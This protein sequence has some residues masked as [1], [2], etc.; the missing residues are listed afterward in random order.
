VSGQ[1]QCSLVIPANV[2]PGTYTLTAFGVSASGNATSAPVIISVERPDAPVEITVA[3]ASLYLP[4]GARAPLR[5]MGTYADGTQLDISHSASTTFSSTSTSVATVDTQGYVTAVGP[6]HGQVPPHIV[7][8]NS[9]N[10]PVVVPPALS[11]TPQYP[12]LYASQRAQFSAF[13]SGMAPVAVN[14]SVSP[15]IGSINNSGVYTAPKS[16]TAQ[17]AVKVIATVRGNPSQ[18]ISTEVVLYPPVSISIMPNT[19]L[20]ALPGQT[21]YFLQ[22]VL[23][24]LDNNVDWSISPKNAGTID[25]TGRYTAP[26]SFT[27]T[28]TVTVTATSIADPSKTASSSVILQP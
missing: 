23:N 8:N 19:P 21:I 26:A 25:N 20:I 10:I 24:A 7:V 27:T 16:I 9:I 2:S 3:P 12:V 13:E 17:Q 28:Q 1:Y 14:W 5:V 18:S 11:I 4:V 6:T 22:T 15:S